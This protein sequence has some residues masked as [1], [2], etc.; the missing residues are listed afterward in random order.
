MI[1]YDTIATLKSK[2]SYNRH[3]NL[4]QSNFESSTIQFGDPNRQGLAS[5]KQITFFDNINVSERS[6][7][8]SHKNS[9]SNNSNNQQQQ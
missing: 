8:T 2:W 3:P 5:V 9:N 4:F 1:Q 7:I 6:I